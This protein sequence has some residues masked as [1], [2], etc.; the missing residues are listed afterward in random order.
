MC[1]W[2][3]IEAS[4]SHQT[5]TKSRSQ[6]DIPASDPSYCLGPNVNV[7]KFNLYKFPKMYI[8]HLTKAPPRGPHSAG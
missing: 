3:Q 7:F 1:A 4:K 2:A 6:I 5:E 8:S